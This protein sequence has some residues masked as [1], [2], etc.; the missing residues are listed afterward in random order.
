MMKFT[1]NALATAML[2]GCAGLSLAATIPAGVQLHAK[3]EMVRNNG[4][5]PDTLD[6]ARAEG[7][8]AN[9]VIRD[10]FE[11]LTAVDGAG[12]TVP[13]RGRELET[14]RCQDLGLQT[15]AKRQVVQR[16]PGDC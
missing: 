6:P 16:R 12:N 1:K 4:S 14:G 11:G 9:N 13:W 7:V 8:P 5:E 3:Q 2:L 10:L 15:A